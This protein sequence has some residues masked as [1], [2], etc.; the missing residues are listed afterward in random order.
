MNN[1]SGYLRT[2]NTT[3]RVPT[4]RTAYWLT[5]DFNQDMNIAVEFFWIINAELLDQ[6]SLAS[7]T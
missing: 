1:A 6:W 4:P 5:E 2:D 7:L 3:G